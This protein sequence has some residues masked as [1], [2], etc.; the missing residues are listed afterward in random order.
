D[1]VVAA[2]DGRVEVEPATRSAD[3]VVEVPVLGVDAGRVEAAEYVEALATVGREG[4][5]VGL[6]LVGRV[7]E[8]RVADA[9]RM[10][11]RR[12]DGPPR[13]AV[14]QR[15]DGAARSRRAGPL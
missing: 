8:A 12:R 2:A 5:R 13:V 1:A 4:D 7:A 9:E 10:R 14:A 15:L 6:A 3:A 11:Q